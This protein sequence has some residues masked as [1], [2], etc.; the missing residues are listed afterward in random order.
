MRELPPRLGRRLVARTLKKQ[1]LP[2]QIPLKM[3]LRT[4]MKWIAAGGPAA[5]ALVTPPVGIPLGVAAGVFLLVD[6]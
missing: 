3:L 1:D 4:G 6:P 2:E 5:L